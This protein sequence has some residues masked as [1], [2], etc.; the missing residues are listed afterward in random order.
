MDAVSF[1]LEEIRE[2]TGIFARERSAL[3]IL[4]MMDLSKIFLRAQPNPGRNAPITHL[5]VSINQ[6]IL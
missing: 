4:F 2:T 5:M 6:K 3:M 1:L